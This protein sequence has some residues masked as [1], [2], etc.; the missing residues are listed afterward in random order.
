MRITFFL[1]VHYYIGR[2]TIKNNFLKPNIDYSTYPFF[3]KQEQ[4]IYNFFIKYIAY[5]YSEVM[6]ERIDELEKEETTNE[7]KLSVERYRRN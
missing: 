3:S 6:L 1:K 7:M 5:F 4:E 2:S